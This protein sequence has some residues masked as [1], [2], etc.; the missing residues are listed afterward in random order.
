MHGKSALTGRASTAYAHGM[1][2]RQSAEPS[3]DLVILELPS[4]TGALAHACAC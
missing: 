4:S 3:S 1:A 2:Q